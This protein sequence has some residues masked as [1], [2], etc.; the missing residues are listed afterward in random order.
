MSSTAAFKID[1]TPST[2]RGFDGASETTYALQLEASPA[3]DVYRTEF[4]VYQAADGESPRK[5]KG[6]LDCV[7]D[8]GR[9]TPS[10][11][12][13]AVTARAVV[14]LTTP[15]SSGDSWIVRC[16]AYGPPGGPLTYE[17]MLAVRS[18]HGMRMAIVG[19][20]SQYSANGEA[21]VLVEIV[22]T[23]ETLHRPD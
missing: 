21:D 20:T 4:Q 14:N 23:I 10:Q 2:P 19:E 5:S 11:R 1:G 8:N 6:A 17:R 12:V 9:D 22:Q 7:L 13:E 3:L 16:Y 18:A 15:E